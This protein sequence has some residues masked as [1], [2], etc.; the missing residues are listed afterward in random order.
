MPQPNTNTAGGF[1]LVETVLAIGIV[2]A[3]CIPLVTLMV[4]GSE[5]QREARHKVVYA[6]IIDQV[7]REISQSNFSE[8]PD[9]YPSMAFDQDGVR[10]D[11]PSLPDRF[12][13]ARVRIEPDASLPGGA[14]PSG[15]LT[16][17]IVEIVWDPLASMNSNTGS[18]EARLFATE[19]DGTFQ[20]PEA[21]RFPILISRND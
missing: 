17:V 2:A 14:P 7:T 1:T 16:R 10:L 18:T 19:A 20:N 9:P 21:R 6:Q 4:M 12:Y 15:N 3:V 5:A 13:R 11:D 8:I